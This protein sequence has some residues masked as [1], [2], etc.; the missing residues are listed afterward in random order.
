MPDTGMPRADAASD[1]GRMRRRRALSVLAARLRGEPD[2]VNV[3]L[4][5]DEVVAALGRR[6]E[7]DLGLQTV[8]LE[9]IVGSVDR[10][11]DFDRGFGRR[12]PRRAS[13]G[14]GSPPPCGVASRC[15]R[16]TSTGSASFTSSATG[17]TGCRSRA[18]CTSRRSRRM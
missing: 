13:A 4:P 18:R 9:T 6:G 15:R 1:F 14:S 5:F 2:D 16:W 17:T 10:T 3:I 12:R 7:R 11:R 8:L